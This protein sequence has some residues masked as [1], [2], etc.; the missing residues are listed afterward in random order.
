M[1]IS[2]QG[3]FNNSLTIN[4]LPFYRWAVKEALTKAVGYRILFPEVYI[5]RNEG[6]APTIIMEGNT[7]HTFNNT[8]SLSNIS[9]SISHEKDTAIAFVLVG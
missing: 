7:L 1:S 4:L 5:Q 3:M 6:N 9:I 8:L 2:H